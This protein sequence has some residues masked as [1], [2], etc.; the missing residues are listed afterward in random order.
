[1]NISKKFPF[2][3]SEWKCKCICCLVAPTLLGSS[4]AIYVCITFE[5]AFEIIVLWGFAPSLLASACFGT[6]GSTTFLLL[7]PLCLAMDPWRGFIVQ[8]MH[9]VHVVNIESDFKWCIYLCRS[10]FLLQYL[11]RWK[12][13][14]ESSI[15]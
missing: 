11:F 14:D 2:V 10:L 6:F 1:M 7:K 5:N 4:Y 8:N 3:K 13:T 15:P 9:M 12:I